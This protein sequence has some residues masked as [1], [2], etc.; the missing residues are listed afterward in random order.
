[1][2]IIQADASDSHG[3]PKPGEGSKHMKPFS[4]TR[5]PTSGRIHQELS[6]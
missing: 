2:L 1:M 3:D 4:G 5:I 6:D